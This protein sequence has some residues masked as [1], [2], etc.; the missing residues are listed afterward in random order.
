MRLRKMGRFGVSHCYSV[1]RRLGA[2]TG[3]G[4]GLGGADADTLLLVAE[5]SE[6]NSTPSHAPAT[7]FAARIRR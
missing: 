3:R 7:G 6:E 1:A 4:A 5:P 2:I